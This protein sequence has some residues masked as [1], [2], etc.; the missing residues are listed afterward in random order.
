MSFAPVPSTTQPSCLYSSQGNMICS[1][2][3][4]NADPY[5]QTKYQSA[6]PSKIEKYEN[7]GANMINMV[8]K[9]AGEIGNVF[10]YGKDTFMN[11]VESENSHIFARNKP[12]QFMMQKKS[13]QEEHFQQNPLANAKTATNIGY[14]VSP[15]P[16]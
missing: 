7:Y 12:E 3:N 5:L 4:P 11:D 16:F 6:C 2:K 10:G 1:G 14:A 9:G 8:K 13:F 15:W